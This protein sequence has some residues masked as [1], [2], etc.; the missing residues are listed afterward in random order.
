M[1]EHVCLP[2]DSQERRVRECSRDKHSAGAGVPGP[3]DAQ[4]YVV[5]L[6]RTTLGWDNAWD[7]RAGNNEKARER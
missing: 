1:F 6:I 2:S 3:D 7:R 4:F 5:G